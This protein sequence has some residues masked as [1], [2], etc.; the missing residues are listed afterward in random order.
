MKFRN[1][2]TAVRDYLEQQ[3]LSERQLD[4]LT[5]LQRSGSSRPASTQRL[6]LLVASVALVA[7]ISA[8]FY[9]TLA[10][11]HAGLEE[12]IGAEIAANH[13]KLKPLEVRTA[14]LEDIR[15]YFTEL[16]FMPAESVHVS[17]LSKNLIGG[18]Y[19]S[20]QGVTAAQLRLRE[21]ETGEVQSFYQTMYDP[22][23]FPGLV[24]GAEPVT[25]YSRG[26]AIDIWVE[27]GILFAMTRSPSR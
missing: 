14:S 21:P 16:D 18:R 22:E 25:V 6:R 8:A 4:E 10:G 20:I 15:R 9:F 17:S 11:R 19:C 13:I 24:E 1:L 3:S 23:I 27:K 7:M 2:R 12:R 26:I 5:A